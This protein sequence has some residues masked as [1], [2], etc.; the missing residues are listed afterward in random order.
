ML[1]AV[2]VCC[3]VAAPSARSTFMG[4]V[5]PATPKVGHGTFISNFANLPASAQPVVAVGSPGSYQLPAAGVLLC[6]RMWWWWFFR[7]LTRA[8]SGQGAPNP[9]PLTHTVSSPASMSGHRSRNVVCVCA[10]RCGAGCRSGGGWVHTVAADG[11][12]GL[13]VRVA[14]NSRA[15]VRASRPLIQCS[16]PVHAMWEAPLSNAAAR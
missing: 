4:G 14:A 8:R 16:L 11:A 6:A 2:R 9:R 3:C 7:P 13:V 1:T 12:C 10:V 15:P 5:E